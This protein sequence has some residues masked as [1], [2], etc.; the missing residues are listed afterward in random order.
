VQALC[1][2]YTVARGLDGKF[3]LPRWSNWVTDAFYDNKELIALE[4]RTV[5]I[6]RQVGGTIEVTAPQRD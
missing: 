1:T 6:K 3:A 5:A 2:T 4:Q